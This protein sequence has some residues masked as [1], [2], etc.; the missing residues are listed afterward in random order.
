MAAALGRQFEAKWLQKPAD[1][2]A[3]GL[4]ATDFSATTDLFQVVSNAYQLRVFPVGFGEVRTLIIVS[5]LPFVPVVLSVVPFN[6]IVRTLGRL[7]V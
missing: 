3:T 5:L 1:V 2:A 6:V 4:E 7:F